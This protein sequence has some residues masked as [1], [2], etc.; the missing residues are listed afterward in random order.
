MYEYKLLGNAVRLDSRSD[1]EG[2]EGHEDNPCMMAAGQSPRSVSPSR[3]GLSLTG[4]A[5]Q[6][7]GKGVVF[8]DGAGYVFAIVRDRLVIGPFMAQ[9]NDPADWAFSWYLDLQVAGREFGKSSRRIR[10]RRGV[11]INESET[12]RPDRSGRPRDEGIRVF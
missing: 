5:W 11:W 2:H 12:D 1:C 9:K 3:N 7:S 4:R 10:A 8:W 6:N